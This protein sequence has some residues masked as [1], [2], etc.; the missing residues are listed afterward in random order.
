MHT[1]KCSKLQLKMKQ[2]SKGMCKFGTTEILEIYKLWWGR[3]DCNEKTL[4]CCNF[5][6]LL[7]SPHQE[8]TLIYLLNWPMEQSPSG[9]ANRF[10][11][12]FPAFYGA[13]NIHYHHKC[14]PT[15]P[16]LSNIDPAHAL[17]STSWRS[18]LILCSHRCLHLLTGPFPTGF[19]TKTLYT[20][21]L[22]RIHTTCPTHLIFLDLTPK[23]YWV[24]T[25]H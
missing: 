14:P 4:A 16:F 7:Q 15:V 12:K 6:S 19:H 9:A 22:S 25:D 18:I 5:S 13:P 20:S 21:L 23:R 8:D 24:S 2:V 3:W 17:I 10:S 1:Y 11:A